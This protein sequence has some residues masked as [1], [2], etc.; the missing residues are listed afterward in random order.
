MSRAKVQPVYYVP[1]TITSFHLH[2]NYQTKD[3][4]LISQMRQLRF[5]TGKTL[6]KDSK[7]RIRTQHCP[8]PKG[9]WLQQGIPCMGHWGGPVLS[10]VLKKDVGVGWK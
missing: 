9:V 4:K 8:T 10:L 3:L 1:G 7:A 5:T 2:H 6:L